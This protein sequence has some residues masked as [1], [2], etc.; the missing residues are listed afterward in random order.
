MFAVDAL[1]SSRAREMLAQG[2]VRDDM[3]RYRSRDELA[4]AI[5]AH[6]VVPGAAVLDFEEQF[7]GLEF[8]SGGGELQARNFD[9]RRGGRGRG[10]GGPQSS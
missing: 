5:K 2:G 1:L 8:L 10:S 4:T 7:G 9:A 6:G 3:S